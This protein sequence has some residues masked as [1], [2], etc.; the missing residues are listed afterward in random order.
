M[1]LNFKL[2]ILCIR[3]FAGMFACLPSSSRGQ[4]R[5]S[6]SMEAELERAVGHHVV[7]GAKGGAASALNYSSCLP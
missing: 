2:I 1:I 7:L 4:K 3:V 6:D 5:A